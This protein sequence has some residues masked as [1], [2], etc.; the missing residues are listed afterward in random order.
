MLYEVITIWQIEVK[1]V[2][3]GRTAAQTAKQVVV[4][5]IREA[6]REIITQ[7]FE[8]KKDEVIT[9]SVHVIT[10]YSI[11]YTKLYESTRRITKATPTPPLSPLKHLH[12]AIRQEPKPQLQLPVKLRQLHPLKAPLDKLNA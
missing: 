3:F 5:K 10:S 2:D 1:N 6:E 4:Q 11:H 7:E 12:P 9:A 8:E